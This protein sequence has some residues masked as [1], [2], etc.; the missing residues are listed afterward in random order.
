LPENRSEGPALVVREEP[1]GI[2]QRVCQR[3]VAELQKAEGALLLAAD[4]A[5]AAAI[6]TVLVKKGVRV[7]ELHHVERSSE[8]N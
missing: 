2:A 7:G 5:W 1:M 4:P 8:S 3:L 6:N